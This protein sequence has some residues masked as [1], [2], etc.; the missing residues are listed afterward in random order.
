MKKI[1]TLLTC[2]VLA[3]AAMAKDYTGTMGIS[4][5][6]EEPSGQEATISLTE[7]TDGSYT[8]T[9][10][11]FSFGAI[12]LGDITVADLQNTATDGT[13]ALSYNGEI[14]TSIGSFPAEVTANVKDDVLTATIN[15]TVFGIMTVNVTFEGTPSLPKTKDYTGAMEITA[16]GQTTS[17]DATISLIEGTDGKYTLTLKNFS[18]GG[19]VNLGDVSIYNLENAATD[20]TIALSYEGDITA[21]NF[22]ELPSKVSASVKDDVLTATISLTSVPIVGTV[23]V[24]FDSSKTAGINDIDTNSDSPVVDI[25]NLQGQ[26]VTDT[27]RKGIYILR[28]AD[29]TTTKVYKR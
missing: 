22:G 20:G 5:N 2:M 7:G 4:L 10:N 6:G 3:V 9:L 18:F 11:D 15:L 8:L 27:N 19:V 23:D 28:K 1:F 24:T 21:G 25:Y 13:V 17:Q 26:K 16:L 12:S 14:T 29:G